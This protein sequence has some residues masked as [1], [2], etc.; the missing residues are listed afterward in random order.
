AA[1]A[2]E[3]ERIADAGGERVADA[4]G[5]RIADAAVAAEGE[6]IADAGGER[7]ADAAV[8]AGGERVAG[9]LVPNLRTIMGRSPA[10]TAIA[11]PEMATR[12][13]DC[14]MPLQC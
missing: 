6:R 9:N 7:V 13:S 4:G 10:R 12:W 3:G 8:A 5:E 2:A 14:Q 1:V 11:I